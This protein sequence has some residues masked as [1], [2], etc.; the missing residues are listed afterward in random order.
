MGQRGLPRRRADNEGAAERCFGNDERYPEGD[1]DDESCPNGDG[2]GD[3]DDHT[4]QSRSEPL[5][6]L[7]ATDRP[8]ANCVP[9]MRKRLVVH[10]QVS[11]HAVG[12]RCRGKGEAGKRE[13]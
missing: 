4:F 11:G 2:D 12:T 3:E 8:T 5:D 10:M 6:W 1:G 9:Q 13:V 7:G